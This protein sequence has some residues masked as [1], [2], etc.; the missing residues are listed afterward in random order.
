[1]D[2]KQWMSSTTQKERT[3]VTRLAGTTVSYLYQLSGQHRRPSSKLAARLEA[4]SRQVTP[5]RVMDKSTLVFG[6]SDIAA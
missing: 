1:M 4:A 2:V 5:D 3:E 6:D